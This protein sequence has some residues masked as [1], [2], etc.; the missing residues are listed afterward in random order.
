MRN[1]EYNGHSIIL[2]HFWT[3]SDHDFVNYK[4]LSTPIPHYKE[5]FMYFTLS[6]NPEFQQEITEVINIII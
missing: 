6:K 4:Q 5:T 2:K 1:E 3:E